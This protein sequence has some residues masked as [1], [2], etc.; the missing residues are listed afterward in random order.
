MKAILSCLCGCPAFASGED[1][2]ACRAG[3]I[4][5]V[6]AHSR[7]RAS[8]ELRLI[9]HTDGRV[10]GELP[11]AQETRLAASLFIDVPFCHGWAS[12]E[13]CSREGW[14]G[15]AMECGGGE[16][17]TPSWRTAIASTS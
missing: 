7:A 11:R 15:T 8:F 4:F 1:E 3:A 14:T 6:P 10:F 9:G 5:T 17:A 13:G 16:L 2:F 12:C